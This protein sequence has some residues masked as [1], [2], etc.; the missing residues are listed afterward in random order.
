MKRDV[1]R[2]FY[3]AE[4]WHIRSIYNPHGSPYHTA[5]D[6]LEMFKLLKEQGFEMFAIDRN[7]YFF[8]K[9]K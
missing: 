2:A 7:V 4:M 9:I 6:E 3:S 5:K 8:K 1:L